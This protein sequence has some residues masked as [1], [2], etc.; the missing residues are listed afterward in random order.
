MK[1]SMQLLSLLT[2][3]LVSAPGWANPQ[4]AKQKNC[5]ACHAIDQ[6]VVG[7]AF[8]DVAKRY[9]DQK[10]AEDKLTAVVLKGGIGAWGDKIGMPANTQVN[11]AEARQLVQWVLE[12]R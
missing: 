10:G 4:L 3:A 8:K 5:M 9:A 12:Q 2:L 1:T 7:P 11:E 6:K